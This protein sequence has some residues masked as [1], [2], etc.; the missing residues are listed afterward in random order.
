[1]LYVKKVLRRHV[2]KL[3]EFTTVLLDIGDRMR[4]EGHFEEG[5]EIPNTEGCCNVECA[6]RPLE[7]GD[8]MVTLDELANVYE[9]LFS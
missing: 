2:G 9:G 7:D 1:M 6:I 4:L 5:D 3:G 8:R